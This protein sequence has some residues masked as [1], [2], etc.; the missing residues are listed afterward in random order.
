[1]I[2]RDQIPCFS[3]HR[4]AKIRPAGRSKINDARAVADGS[5]RHTLQGPNPLI[6]PGTLKESSCRGTYSSLVACVADTGIRG[7]SKIVHGV[8]AAAGGEWT[9]APPSLACVIF[10]IPLLLDYL[11]CCCMV[12]AVSVGPHSLPPPAIARGDAVGIGGLGA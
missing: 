11:Q 12:E 7:G 10:C 3:K 2:V 8:G 9:S 1:V 5:F 4:E 6:L